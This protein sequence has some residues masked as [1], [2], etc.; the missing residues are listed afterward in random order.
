M[1]I[2]FWTERNEHAGGLV[3]SETWTH[4][5]PDV[6]AHREDQIRQCIDHQ[7]GQ[8]HPH[9]NMPFAEAWA[10]LGV[11]DPYAEDSL[12]AMAID[13]LEQAE[14][15]DALR[16]SAGLPPLHRPWTML[17]ETL[18]HTQAYNPGYE[19]LVEQVLQDHSLLVAAGDETQPLELVAVAWQHQSEGSAREG[20]QHQ[21]VGLADLEPIKESDRP[22][23]QYDHDNSGQHGANEV[24]P[25][26][27]VGHRIS[28]QDLLSEA[29]SSFAPFDH[30]YFVIH[31]DASFTDALSWQENLQLYYQSMG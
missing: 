17:S 19:R 4:A 23:D 15:Q 7:G 27:R 25:E 1:R 28:H 12:R 16:H 2:D 14:K 29:G 26:P 3:H 31:S 22:A 10:M 18:A 8:M 6:I 24:M 20:E 9:L 11:T 21:A 30:T 13:T 5:Q